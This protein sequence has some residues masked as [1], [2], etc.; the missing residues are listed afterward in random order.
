M[1]PDPDILQ[2]ELPGAAPEPVLPVAGQAPARRRADAQRNHEL[3][4]CTAR[5]LFAE[6]GPANVSM[7]A[8]AAEAGVG[9]GTIFRA[10]GDRAGLISEIL[11]A[12]ESVL[13]DALI[14][15]PAPLGPGAPPLERIVA[16]GHAYMRFLEDHLDMLQAAEIGP[17]VRYMKGPFQLYRA[18]LTLLVEDVVG[19]SDVDVGYTADILLAP[20]GADFFAYQRSVRERS[21][22][23]LETNYARLAQRVLSCR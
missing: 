14:R 10:F 23:E 3:L 11:G 20:L 15:G 18:H 2:I 4:L 21:L 1:A 6:R 5:R 19:I 13:Q 12:D 9:K 16:F 22:E 8:I 17:G 7:E